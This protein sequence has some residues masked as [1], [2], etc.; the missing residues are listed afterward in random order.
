MSS[1]NNEEPVQQGRE[2]PVE[3]TGTKTRALGSE[4]LQLLMD[5]RSQEGPECTTVAVRPGTT[6]AVR[7]DT[8]SGGE[9]EGA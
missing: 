4:S 8:C 2:G 6:V 7:P 3:P 1:L 5:Q 9:M